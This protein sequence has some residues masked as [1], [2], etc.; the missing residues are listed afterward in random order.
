MRL[1]S[2][3]RFHAWPL[4][5]ALLAGA[6]IL[7]VFVAIRP[8]PAPP[9][10]ALQDIPF[11]QLPFGPDETGAARPFWPSR[12][13]SAG[14]RMSD[15]QRLPSAAECGVCHV[16][17]FQEWAGSLHA[18]ADR[19]LIYDVTVGA[20]EDTNRNGHEM[21]R[22]CEGCH[23]PLE[24]LSG[25]TNRLVSVAPAEVLSEGV[26]CIACHTATAADPVK[27]NGAFTLAL[28]R[29]ELE[30]ETPQG[31]LLL[32]DPRAHIAAFR[33]PD[34]AA[35]MKSADFCGACHTETL[36]R[37]MSQAETEQ[38]AQSTYVE[39]RDSWYAKQNIT[40]Q[41]CHMAPDPAAQVMALRA[42]QV[43]KPER[44]SHRFVGANHFLV[45]QSLGQSLM[46][47]RG[48]LLPGVDGDANHATLA[49]QSRLTEALLRTA[50]GLEL[51]RAAPSEEGLQVEIAVQN[52]GAG[53]NLPTGVSDQKYMW[54]EVT[55]TDAKG[56][57][58]FRSGD[59]SEPR[60]VED[61]DAVAWLEHFLD[62]EGNRITNHLTF[63]TA[64]VVW[65][66]RSIPPRGEDV[67]R[68]E[69]TLPAAAEGPFRLKARLLYRVALPDLIYQNL[70]RDIVPAPFTLAE[71][72]ATLPET[73]R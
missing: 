30:R 1:K 2:Q 39:W 9:G 40:C 68:Y 59:A 69:V 70:R 14:G 31:A 49:E 45:D 28:E 27:G 71:L 13:E 35:L 57:I 62:R 43:A 42:G 10:V 58:V 23:A 16:R 7:A 52:L 54:L 38:H 33:A 32:A 19:D 24:M 73:G 18:V 37:S 65:I 5:G 26:T 25:R 63:S 72:T 20:N 15:P 11:Y 55:V 41:D 29:A 64:E 61:P 21:A 4:A 34:T 3:L 44:Y 46:L 12:I 47:L 8:A 60:G 50:A 66:R 48:G 67:A 17:E 36:D 53:H 6:L 51:R 22:F 56:A